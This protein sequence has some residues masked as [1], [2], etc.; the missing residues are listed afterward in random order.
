MALAAAAL[1][2]F[3]LALTAL[4]VPGLLSPDL[5]GNLAGLLSAFMGLGAL[6]SLGVS[7]G[8]VSGSD[9]CAR[10]GFALAIAFVCFTLAAV[11]LTNLG[12]IGLVSMVACLE[13]IALAFLAWMN[14]RR[15]RRS[16]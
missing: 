5:D 2:V 14:V 1:L 7:V 16:G 4:L 13:S 9:E 15:Y 6:A 3:H 11:F 8:T 10:Y 12:G